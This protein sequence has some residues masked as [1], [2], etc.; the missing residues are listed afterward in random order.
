MTTVRLSQIYVVADE[1]KECFT[2]AGKRT[3]A[4]VAKVSGDEFISN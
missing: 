3:Y 1:G 2:A 4:E